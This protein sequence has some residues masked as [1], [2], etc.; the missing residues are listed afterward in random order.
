MYLYIHTF[1]SLFKIILLY[2]FYIKTSKMSPIEIPFASDLR[3]RNTDFHTCELSRFS[4]VQLCGPYGLKPT[5][6]L[7]PWGSPDK[8]TEV[9]GHALLQGILPTQRLNLSLLSLVPWQTGSLPLVPPGK[10]QRFPYHLL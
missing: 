7:C 10:P 3:N 4:H 1:T 8:N 2:Y 6:L 5:R 9:G